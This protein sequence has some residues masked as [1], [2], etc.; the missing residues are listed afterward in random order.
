MVPRRSNRGDK[1]RFK[2]Y[3]KVVVEGSRSED[4]Y[5][6]ASGR[7]HRKQKHREEG[8]D[9]FAAGDKSKHKKRNYRQVRESSESVSSSEIEQKD[10]R[11]NKGL[12]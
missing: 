3:R 2:R 8:E 10:E 5:P 7:K 11:P 1:H 4:D 9:R 6:Y 12:E